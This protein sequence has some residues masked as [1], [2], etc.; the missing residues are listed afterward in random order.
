MNFP[1][2][3][4]AL[5]IVQPE[6]EDCID[7]MFANDTVIECYTVGEPTRLD[8]TQVGAPGYGTMIVGS[9]DP[10]DGKFKPVLWTAF[11]G[12]GWTQGGGGGIPPF[13]A[14]TFTDDVVAVDGMEGCDC[15]TRYPWPSPPECRP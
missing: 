2:L 13:S 5:C 10:E 15:H 8:V 4:L 1:L 14:L 3:A 11:A 9:H 12:R 6:Q 7:L